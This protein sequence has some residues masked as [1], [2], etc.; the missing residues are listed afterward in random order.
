[1]ASYPNLEQVVWVQEEPRN[2]GARAFMRVRMDKI[3]PE[4]VE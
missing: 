4:G 2:M 1:M 3:L